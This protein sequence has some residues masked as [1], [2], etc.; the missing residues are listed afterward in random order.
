VR[1]PGSIDSGATGPSGEFWQ[2]L[3]FSI[4]CGNI[5]R[6][7]CNTEQIGSHLFK[8]WSLY[9]DSKI[10]IRINLSFADIRRKGYDMIWPKTSDDLCGSLNVL[11]HNPK[12][13][14]ADSRT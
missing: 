12:D 8:L 2:A 9:I 3:A 13:N 7:I 1:Q 11:V 5:W 6:K 4:A 14:K 10:F